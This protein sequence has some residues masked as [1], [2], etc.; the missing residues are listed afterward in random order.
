MSSIAFAYGIGSEGPD[1][2][3]IDAYELFVSEDLEQVFNV[4]RKVL[5][6]RSGFDQRLTEGLASLQKYYREVFTDD[7]EPGVAIEILLGDAAAVQLYLTAKQ[8][9]GNE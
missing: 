7:I 2:Y 5:V 1:G 6:V 3:E 4:A 9:S 8:E